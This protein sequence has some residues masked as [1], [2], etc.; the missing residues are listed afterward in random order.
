MK[1]LIFILPI[2][3]ITNILY[4]QSVNN[5]IKKGNDA[6]KK[7]DY[8][9]AQENYQEALKRE[10]GNEAAHFNLGNARKRLKSAV[11]AEKQYDEIIETTTDASLKAKAY[12]NKGLS[13]IEQQKIKEAIDAFKQSLILSPTDNDARENLQKAM[14]AQQKQNQQKQ[15]PQPKQNKQPQNKNKL[16]AQKA[17]QYLQQLR[18]QEKRLQSELQKKAVNEQPDIDW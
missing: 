9:A 2:F 16:T 6:Y 1:F 4:G 8:K 17:E 11:D 13:L 3:F 7:G 18:D 5:A 10:P 14:N 15:S 12:Y